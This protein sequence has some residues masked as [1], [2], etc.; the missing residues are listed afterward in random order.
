MENPGDGAP[1][2]PTDQVQSGNS[3]SDTAS[4]APNQGRPVDSRAVLALRIAAR[5][6]ML[7]HGLIDLDELFP[8]DIVEAFMKVTGEWTSRHEAMDLHFEKTHREICEARL[9]RWRRTP[10]NG[11]KH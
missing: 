5:Y 11:G 6:E 4:T 3:A 10:L 7:R 8:P 2:L 1:G 9:A